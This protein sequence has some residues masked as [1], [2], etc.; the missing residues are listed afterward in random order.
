MAIALTPFEGFCG[1]RP[2]REI[3]D[4]A[5]HVPELAR[6]LALDDHGRF[7]LQAA[8]DEQDRHWA[9]GDVSKLSLI[10]I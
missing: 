2:V 5:T 4:F 9:A 6:I 7:M 8:A 1:F 3:S 10:H